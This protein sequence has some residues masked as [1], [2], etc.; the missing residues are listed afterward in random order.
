MSKALVRY[1]RRILGP[2]CEAEM[3]AVP[4]R[5]HKVSTLDGSEVVV[6]GNI[7]RCLSPF[8]FLCEK[9]L[10]STRI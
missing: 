3:E 8:T 9:T 4:T 10:L 7:Q 5:V 1:K 6:L 2:T